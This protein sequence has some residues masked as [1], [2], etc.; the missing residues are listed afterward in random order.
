MLT[1]IEWQL[2]GAFESMVTGIHA[3]NF[4]SKVCYIGSLAT[5]LLL[6]IFAIQYTKMEKWLTRKNLTLLCTIPA[7][8]FILTLTNEWHNL[9][10]TSYT[11]APDALNTIIYGHGP[12]FWIMIA[13]NY[14]ILLV[15]TLILLFSGKSSRKIYR[16]QLELIIV[17]LVFPWTGN[18]LYLL[19][20]G[21]FP[22]QDLTIVGFTLTGL[23]LSFNLYQFKFLDLVPMARDRLM[24]KMNDGI[25]VV[26]NKER[27]VDINPAAKEIFSNKPEK[28]LG[29][30][31]GQLFPDLKSTV[32]K[33]TCARMY[34]YTESRRYGE[35]K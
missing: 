1:I 28:L 7:I 21:P 9:I 27:I 30:N 3:K 29:K 13:Y 14:L 19:D 6:F 12:G 26:D 31:I 35:M 2:C 8:I 4:W 25:I 34:I 10:W 15:A 16:Q 17:A 22:G 32:G 23:V 11:P 33:M 5:P 18:I 20:M 24:E